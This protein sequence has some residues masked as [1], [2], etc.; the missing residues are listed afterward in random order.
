MVF[1]NLPKFF[2]I[3]FFSVKE[4]VICVPLNKSI[5]SIK[6]FYKPI[7]ARAQ[8]FHLTTRPISCTRLDPN[9]LL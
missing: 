8:G 1:G 9:Y 3:R 7:R 5:I 4:Y 2:L 6:D